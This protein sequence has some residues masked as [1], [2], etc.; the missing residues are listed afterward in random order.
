MPLA[1]PT[2]IPRTIPYAF[3]L[4]VPSLMV[5]IDDKDMSYMKRPSAH[6]S[7]WSHL[8]IMFVTGMAGLANNNLVATNHDYT[9]RSLVSK[10]CSKIKSMVEV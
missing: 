6:T 4:G 3:F 10:T 5:N 7:G 9:T 1:R 2:C 8:V